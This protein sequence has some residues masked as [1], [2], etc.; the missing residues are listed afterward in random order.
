MW[1]RLL[2]LLLIVTP[3]LSKGQ[4]AA[5]INTF[6]VKGIVSVIPG[7]MISNVLCINNNSGETIKGK[8]TIISPGNWRS[9]ADTSKLYEIGTGDTIFVPVRILPPPSEINSNTQYPVIAELREQK[10]DA[11]LS[12]SNFFAS[13][14]RIV[15]WH[16]K[17][18]PSDVFYFKQND[19]NNVFALNLQNIGNADQPV[20]VTIK[21]LSTKLC[22]KDSTNKNIDYAFREVLLRQN[23][24]TTITFRVCYKE[25]KRN[26]TRIDIDN[27]SPKSSTDELAFTMNVR[28]SESKIGGN[29]FFSTNNNIKFKKPANI[30]RVNKWGASA[31]P[32][33]VELNTFNIMGNLPG[34]NL[35]LRGSYQIGNERSFSY[36]LQQNFF[37]FRPTIQTLRNNFFTLNYADKKFAISAGNINGIFGAGIPVGGKGFSVQYK[38][39]QNQSF[40]IFATRGPGFLG[41]PSRFAYGAVH[42]IKINRDISALS[43]IGQVRLLNTSTLLNF[44]S[45]RVNFHRKEHNISLAGTLTSASGNNNTTVGILA[46]A[47]YNG[48]Y[49]DK[50]L[51]TSL[52]MAYNNSAFGNFN[53]ERFQIINRTQFRYSKKLMLILQNNFNNNR[54]A[55]TTFDFLTFNNQL[56]VPINYEKF[57]FS[58]GLLYNYAR[59]GFEVVHFRGVG[60]DYSY[61]SLDEN[62]RVFSSTRMGYNRLSNRPGTGELFTFTTFNSI[63]YKV[64]TIV[65]RYIYGPTVSPSIY[66]NISQSPYPQSLYLSLQHQYQFKNQCYVIQNNVTYTVN[67]GARSQNAGIFSELYY[68]SYSN[69][70]FKLSVGYNVSYFGN[71][72]DTLAMTTDLQEGDI[73]QNLQVGVGI[74]KEFGIMIPKK[75]AKTRYVTI[76]YHAFIDNN[77][78]GI[79]DRDEVDLEN[80][81]VNNGDF[82]VITD[83]YGKATVLNIKSGTYPIRVFALEEIYGFYPQITDSILLD[84]S[85][86]VPIPFKKA[87]KISGT[88]AVNKIIN[89]GVPLLL[90][91]IR[92]TAVASDGRS[93]SAVTDKNGFY[94]LYVPS[95]RY[96]LTINDNQFGENFVL[97]QNNV[98]VDLVEGIAAISQSFVFN[99]RPRKINKKKF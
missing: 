88:I 72:A 35:V 47:G 44:V 69:W 99:E 65:A 55:S 87:V 67:K 81:V 70:R 86:V 92:I 45:S 76:T 1:A 25:D 11:L 39:S 42:Q 38:F 6:W 28:T 64:L 21:S 90:D 26:S 33:I 18:L 2:L 23:L 43:L 31:I 62:I 52:R 83:K 20:F 98:V 79:R 9:L 66:F 49:L 58:G 5:G 24:D 94:F 54:S 82:E 73:T 46:A 50:R 12:A 48:A 95:G 53:T 91:N 29:N 57:R 74:R 68:Y 3:I 10:S 63:Q 34:A 51:M 89:D 41:A 59:F 77:G 40:G 60:L 71:T 27:Y 14:P 93:Y 16:V 7:S 32:V 61:F 22:I 8:I 97:A 96:T 37:S 30:F 80:V 13:G 78:N 56:F 84:N 15:G 19:Q 17:T 85:S 4:N 36:F 75:F